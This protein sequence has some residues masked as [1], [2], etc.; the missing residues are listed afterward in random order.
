[1]RG[2]LEQGQKKTLSGAEIYLNKYDVD[3]SKGN[4]LYSLKLLIVLE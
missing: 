4:Y 3:P 1:M 2:K